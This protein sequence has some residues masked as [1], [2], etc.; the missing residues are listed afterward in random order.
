MASLE[1]SAVETA[2]TIPTP[3]ADQLER[4]VPLSRVRKDDYLRFVGDLSPEAS[5]L[6]GRNQR[7]GRSNTSRHGDVGVWLGEQQDHQGHA[8]DHRDAEPGMRA[9]GTSPIQPLG[10]TCL[11]TFGQRLRQEC[12][13]VLP[14]AYEL[15]LM[16][17]LFYAKIDPIFPILHD[18]TLERPNAMES[19]ALQ[20]C[21]CL[22]ASLDPSLK[23]HLRLHHVEGVLSQ[24]D[25]RARV[26]A[27]VKQSLDMA[28]IRDTIILLQVCALMA[29]HASEPG[30]SDVSPYY[31]ALAVHHSQTL[32]LHLGWPDEGTKGQGFT[33][34]FWCVWALDRLSA[35][36]NGRPVLIHGRDMDQR[37]MGSE[38]AQIPSFRLFIRIS[39]FLDKVISQYRP[40][41]MQ[42]AQAAADDEPAFEDLVRETES[43]EIGNALLGELG[44]TLAKIKAL[45]FLQ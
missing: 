29:F 24:A 30:C 27:A 35:A 32:G 18:T 2:A 19:V 6:A 12:M 45:P 17:E 3:R 43:M 11:Q 25:F 26:A 13:S 22:T 41:A 5:F 37:I 8:G 20:Q 15:G 42:E 28:F 33:R 4:L 23:S 14:P 7:D 21:I 38:S 31:S 34:M 9:T 16:I 40:H 36:T 1:P 10:L 44:K 39:E